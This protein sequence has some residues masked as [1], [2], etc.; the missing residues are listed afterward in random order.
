MGTPR[1]ANVEPLHDANIEPSPPPLPSPAM[2][3]CDTS[4]VVKMGY[5]S[6]VNPPPHPSQYPEPQRA[7]CQG[8]TSAPVYLSIAPK[9]EQGVLL[10]WR[11]TNAKSSRS[12]LLPARC[13]LLGQPIL[14]VALPAAAPQAYLQL[15][16]LQ[17]PPLSFSPLPP[18]QSPQYPTKIM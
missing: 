8:Q 7:D 6:E 10:L 13:A 1:D 9:G 15:P 3:T 5:L 2:P 11:S 14:F 17:S 4:R 16:P 12:P 18:A